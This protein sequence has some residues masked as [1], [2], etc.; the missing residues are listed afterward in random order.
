MKSSVPS[1]I[2]GA[3]ATIWV[4]D[5]DRAVAFYRDALGLSLARHVPGEWAEFRL[6]DGF[7]IGLHKG[8]P[9]STA[10]K[11]GDRGATEVGLEIRGLM[12]DAVAALQARGVAF[13]GGIVESPPV[14][15]AF[16]RDPDGTALYLFCHA[17]PA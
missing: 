1:P 6:S 7:R 9:K 17:P 3:T 2:R 11:P 14:R 10:M 4:T 12:E 8:D 16:L 5:V 13:Q 15:L